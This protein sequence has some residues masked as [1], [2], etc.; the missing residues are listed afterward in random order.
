[1]YHKLRVEEEDVR[2][3]DTQNTVHT[4]YNTIYWL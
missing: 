4:Q 3:K 2:K 1:M